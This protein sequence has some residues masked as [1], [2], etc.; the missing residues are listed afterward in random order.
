[1]FE[2]ILFG[3]GQTS[4][5]DEAVTGWGGDTYVTWMDASG[6]TCL[7]DSFVGD[8]PDDTQELAAA[9]SQW[10]PDVKATVTAPAGQPGTFTVCS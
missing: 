2:E 7:R 4:N 6:K 3:W 8:T 1:M 9:L 5:V 10:A